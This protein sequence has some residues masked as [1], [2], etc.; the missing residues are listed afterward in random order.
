MRA[1]Q[2]VLKNTK[3]IEC[4]LNAGSSENYERN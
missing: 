3:G 2:D 4:V 1:T